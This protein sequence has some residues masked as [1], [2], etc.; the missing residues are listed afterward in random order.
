MRGMYQKKE[1][2]IFI[3]QNRRKKA[4]KLHEIDKH[5]EGIRI[6]LH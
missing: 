5:A 1:K 4:K 2:N 6:K 3:E